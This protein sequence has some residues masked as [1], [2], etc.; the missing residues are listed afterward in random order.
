MRVLWALV[1]LLVVS[2]ARAG[3]VRGTVKLGD[4]PRAVEPISGYWRVENFQLPVLPAADARG[5]AVVILEPASAAKPAEPP[6]ITVELRGLRLDPR[7]VAV[8]V[9]AS[10]Q[11]KNGDRTPHTLYVEHGS[12]M[13][14]PEATPAGQSRTQKF[15]VAGEYRVRDEEYPHLSGM[16][17]AVA[18]PYSAIVDGS[19]NF[20]LEAPDGKYTARVWWRGA[21]VLSQTVTVGHGDL[22]L[23][24]PRKKGE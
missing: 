13:M 4:E 16:I 6:T 7:V 3:S 18:S 14:A 22:N 5:D 17:L 15:L 24:V 20:K 10:V 19:G 8:P 2:E 9:G 11:F 21:W 23:V 12:A 1:W